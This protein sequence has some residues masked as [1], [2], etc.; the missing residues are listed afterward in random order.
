MGELHVHIIP[1]EAY[2]QE[3]LVKCLSQCPCTQNEMPFIHSTKQRERKSFTC[4]SKNELTMKRKFMSME[5][6]PV[7]NRPPGG[8]FF[9]LNSL[10]VALAVTHRHSVLCLVN[11]SH[12]VPRLSSSEV[13]LPPS[14]P[15]HDLITF[16]P[17]LLFQL[18]ICFHHSQS[19]HSQ[20]LK[21]LQN[22]QEAYTFPPSLWYVL[23]R[24]QNS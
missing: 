6:F 4:H 8:H 1:T 22:L 12:K 24:P 19:T 14:L 3:W 16:F 10:S 18:P 2:Y 15:C 5:K 23:E 20:M 7:D 17:V 21:M 11:D 13:H 9:T